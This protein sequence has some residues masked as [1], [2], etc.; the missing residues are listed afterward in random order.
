[1]LKLKL[2][3]LQLARMSA[4]MGRHCHASLIT[5]AN[6]RSEVS[7]STSCNIDVSNKR[8]ASNSNTLTLAG[9]SQSASTPDVVSDSRE[10]GNS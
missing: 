4:N 1:M 8:D 7:N 5:D 2:G 3:H 9:R 10:A 6:K